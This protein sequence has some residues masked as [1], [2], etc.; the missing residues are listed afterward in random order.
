MRII[1]EDDYLKSLYKN[2]ETVGK[3]KFGPLIE[4]AFIKRVLQI[5]QS[6]DTNSLRKIKSLHFEQLKGDLKGKLS[7]R[8]IDGFRLI[9]RIENDGANNRV[10]IIAIEELSNHYSK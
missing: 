9:F 10:E 3:P 2:G 5:E 6:L 1:I 4:R 7:I 8:V